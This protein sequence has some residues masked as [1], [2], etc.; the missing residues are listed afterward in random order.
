MS[1]VFS[2]YF[3]SRVFNNLLLSLFFYLGGGGG[4]HSSTQGVLRLNATRWHFLAPGQKS[5]QMNTEV[6]EANPVTVSE[7]H[8]I[9]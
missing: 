7:C 8:I 3:C 5:G 1:A 6:V 9:V 2:G 4:R